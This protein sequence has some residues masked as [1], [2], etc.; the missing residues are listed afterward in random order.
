V[1]SRGVRGADITPAATG[2]GVLQVLD[3]ERLSRRHWVTVFTAGMGFFTDA[4]DLFIIGTVTAVLTPIWHLTTSQLAVL[5]SI[6]LLAS[7]VGALVFGKLMD[8]V[9]RK[10]MYGLEV[11]L[12]TLGAVLS[13]FSWSFTSLL[14]FRI[15]VGA[16]VGGD[17]ATSAVITSE[18]ANRKD[19]GRLVGTVFAMQGIGLLA[20]PIIASILL[21]TGVGHG[22]AWRLMLG[23][24]ALPAASV[25]YLRRKI[26]ETPRY[27]LLAGHPEESGA[28]PVAG[29]PKESI[30]VPLPGRSG[31]GAAGRV[32]GGPDPAE[33]QTGVPRRPRLTRSP[34]LLRLV[35][36]AGCW[37]LLDAAFYGN[38]VSSPLILR[39]LQPKGSLLSHTLISGGIF[40]VFAL[41]GYWIAAALMDRLGRKRI[42]WQGFLVMAA[43]FGAIAAIPGAATS[44]WPFLALFGVSYFFT[45]F[46]P[47]MTTFVFPSEVFPTAVR[48]TGD[49]ISAAAGKLGAFTGALLVPHLLISFGLSGVMG[50]MAV[51]AG[52]G[53]VLTLLALPEPR[54]LS[55][56][57][58]SGDAGRSGVTVTVAPDRSRDPGEADLGAPGPTP[59]G[60]ADDLPL[61]TGTGQ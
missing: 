6:S 19:R 37:F 43:A 47:N 29:D 14:V 21:G 20:G 61:A 42:Q 58:A 8:L 32:A 51:V 30:V 35:G 4:Y 27:A 2:V 40:L 7:V 39:A 53:L 10:T 33:R 34:F 57:E 17:Y 5:N 36:T 41:P 16:G 9:G 25:I 22:L 60:P 24:G 50:T 49:G 46:G 52:A 12:L 18:Y 54:G 44:T 1:Q 3:E 13:A 38:A 31:A 11:T 59:D 45:E 23:I 15:L 28:D 48:G 56:E 55:L 26:S